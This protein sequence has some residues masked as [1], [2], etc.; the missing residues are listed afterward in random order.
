VGTNLV[1]EQELKKKEDKLIK[2]TKYRR[3]LLLDTVCGKLGR[4]LCH[5]MLLRCTSALKS[6]VVALNRL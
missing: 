3:E 2:K 5:P 6:L 4:H 1:V